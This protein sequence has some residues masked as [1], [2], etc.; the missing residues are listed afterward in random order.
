MGLSQTETKALKPLSFNWSLFELDDC[1]EPVVC[2]AKS[3]QAVP[4]SEV[5]IIFRHSISFSGPHFQP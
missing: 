2:D 5:E 4:L 1:V 3:L